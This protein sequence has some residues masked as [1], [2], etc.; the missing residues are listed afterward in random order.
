MPDPLS[1]ALRS[2]SMSRTSRSVPFLALALS[3]GLAA[4]SEA[5]VRT[6]DGGAGTLSW[7]DANNWSPDGVPTASDD[8]VIDV[9]GQTVTITLATGSSTVNTIASNE[10]LQLGGTLTIASTSTINGLVTVTGTLGGAGAVTGGEPPP[11]GGA[12]G[13]GRS[14]TGPEVSG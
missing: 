11:Q 5:A 1:I 2:S 7:T 3:L 4:T 13:C 6:W 14:N 12:P 8:V 9:P 10:N